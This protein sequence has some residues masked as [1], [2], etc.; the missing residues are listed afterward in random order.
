MDSSSSYLSELN[1]GIAPNPTNN[2]FSDIWGEYERVILHSLVTSFG[3]DFLVHD[4]R[5]G[6]VDTVQGVRETGAFK[7]SAYA[8]KYEERGKYS[9]HDYHSDDSYTTVTAEA[10]G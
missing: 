7:N 5:D 9:T 4:Q 1:K 8:Q 2:V 3:L 10:R 6:D